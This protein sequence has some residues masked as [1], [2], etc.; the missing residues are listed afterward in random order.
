MQR[1]DGVSINLN[2]LQRTPPGVC[3][4]IR[5]ESNAARF[6]RTVLRGPAHI[7]RVAGSMALAMSLFRRKR[8]AR[9]P[10]DRRETP[11]PPC[12]LSNRPGEHGPS[13]ATCRSDRNGPTARRSATCPCGTVPGG[14]SHHQGR[15]ASGLGPRLRTAPWKP[16]FGWFVGL[17]RSGRDSVGIPI[18]FEKA[19]PVHGRTPVSA[20][21][22]DLR[23]EQEAADHD[24]SHMATDV[25]VPQDC[26]NCETRSTLNGLCDFLRLGRTKAATWNCPRGK[27]TFR[28]VRG[29]TF[30]SKKKARRLRTLPRAG[31]LSRRVSAGLLP[32]RHMPHAR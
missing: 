28:R 14:Q 22:N 25:P 2:Q 23:P 4:F 12:Y 17:S 29:D 20:A 5:S 31:F 8:G 24:D 13:R 7:V 1:G 15:L 32:L 3:T 21:R 9:L 30:P 27:K 26:E 10:G 11:V 19:R 18:Q 16:G 6:E